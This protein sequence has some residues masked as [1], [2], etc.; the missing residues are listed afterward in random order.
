MSHSWL[1]DRRNLLDGYQ[2]FATIA[3]TLR[4]HVL[5]EDRDDIEVDIILK[6]KTIAD[7]QNGEITP[8]LLWFVGRCM[9]AD[10][11]RR[12][13]KERKRT[14]RIFTGGR[15]EIASHSWEYLSCSSDSDTQLDARAIL[16]TLPRR[17]KRIG[18]RL[19][20]GERLNTADKCYLSRQRA[21][22]LRDYDYGVGDAEAEQIRHLWKQGL[23]M[24][25]IARALGRSHTTV[26]K[27][28]KRM[29]LT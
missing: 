4:R 29:A 8:A 16:N 20:N 18:E 28:L 21:R 15:G 11:W 25:Q 27:Y 3:Y 14:A 9:I 12:K 26:S 2:D 13:E 22:L 24:C 23:S 6:L 17:L 1:Y 5:S 10:Y 19:V 7:K